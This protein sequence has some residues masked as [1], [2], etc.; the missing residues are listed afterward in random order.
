MVKKKK[1]IPKV[2]RMT[3]PRP[4]RFGVGLFAIGLIFVLMQKNIQTSLFTNLLFAILFFGGIILVNYGLIKGRVKENKK[5][6]NFLEEYN[7]FTFIFFLAVLILALLS[8][9]VHFSNLMIMCLL[10]V[11]AIAF[12]V[13]AV[14]TWIFYIK[15]YKAL[16]K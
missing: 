1:V 3:I 14:L 16:K 10:F 4:I 9:V 8:F 11:F 7:A 13:D 15:T 2:N 5:Y 6:Q 12:I